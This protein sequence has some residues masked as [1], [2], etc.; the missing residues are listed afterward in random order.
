MSDQTRVHHRTELLTLF[1]LERRWNQTRPVLPS[2]AVNSGPILDRRSPQ[3]GLPRWEMD[4]RSPWPQA[5]QVDCCLEIVN[6]VL[7]KMLLCDVL[8]ATNSSM[9][10]KDHHVARTSSLDTPKSLTA[11][12]KP[13]LR[14]RAALTAS[15]TSRDEHST[16]KKKKIHGSAYRNIKLRAAWMSRQH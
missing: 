7:Q 14:I 15:C 10:I 6:T 16:V 4:D 9:S 1:L 2:V 13:S 5:T 11:A 12:V 3:R 8:Q